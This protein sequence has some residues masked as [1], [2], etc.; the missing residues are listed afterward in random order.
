VWNGYSG[1]DADVRREQ[2]V[3]GSRNVAVVGLRDPQGRLL[4]VRTRRL[5]ER[6][7]PIGGGM[8]PAD[9]SPVETLI[10]ELKEEADA[11]FAEDDFRPVIEARYDFGNGKVHFFEAKID[12]RHQTL[13][14]NPHEI[15]EHR[16]FT[17]SEARHL[18]VFP[19]TRR[20][21]SAIG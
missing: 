20:F 11:D 16:W 4:M 15:V 2:I 7:Q 14:F 6:W 12:P 1:N 21:L 18:P 3:N 5:P 13:H 9:A 10:R 17:V 19:A 8:E